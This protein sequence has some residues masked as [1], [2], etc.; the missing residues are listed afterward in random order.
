MK[1]KLLPIAAAAAVILAVAAGA[2]TGA[3]GPHGP[4]AAPHTQIVGRATLDGLDD[5][6]A[7]TVRG[8]S[9]GASNTGAGA[10][11]GGAGAGKATIDD[12][13]L[14]RHVDA[15]SA[16]LVDDAATGR[17]LR[18]AVID[19]FV[20]GTQTP[21]A[22]YSLGDVR[23]AKVLH[24]GDLE[25]IALASATVDEQSL[26]AGPQLAPGSQLGTLQLD[27]IAAPLA[28]SDDR[29]EI[30]SADSSTGGGAGNTA[31]FQPLVVSLAHGAASPQLVDDVLTGRHLETATL[32]TPHATYS[33]TDVV[34][35]SVKDEATGAPGSQPS[36]EIELVASHVAV[37]SQ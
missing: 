22:R 32:T 5:G 17:H 26:A 13:E 16:P 33:L 8:F 9:L 18:S 12:V 29:F 20:P 14:V 19:L 15:L 6:N 10:S 3:Q 24:V 7:F 30:D 37:S 28:V 27:G 35:Q 36:E 31:T 4:A 23:V 2:A 25:T 21:Y 11:G 34:V 1:R